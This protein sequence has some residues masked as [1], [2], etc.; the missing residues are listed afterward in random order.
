[1]TASTDRSSSVALSPR[2]QKIRENADRHA[3]DRDVWVRR[4]AFYYREDHRYFRFLVP[5]G[6]RVLDLGCGF[7]DLLAAVK[8]SYGVGLDFSPAMIEVARQR[9]PHLK[10]RVADIE[11]PRSFDGLEGPFDV[12]IV[13]DTIGDMEDVV[14]TFGNLHALC[15]RDTRIIISYHSPLWR[16]LLELGTKWGGR[17]PSE[18]SNWLSLGDISAL[19]SLAGF[20]VI[21]R[22][23]RQIMP[24]RLFGL[25][26]LLNRYVGTVPLIR[27]LSL[28]NYVVV[29]SLKS[30][31]PDYSSC[32]VLIPARNEKGNI[33][34]AVARLP[35]FCEDIEIMF[36][37]G[38]SHDG[39]LEEMERVKACHPDKDIK[40]LVQD[41][42]G[43]G[44]AVRKGF[45]QARG[46][47]LMILDADLTTPPEQMP[48]F[49]EVIRSGRGE[50]ANGTRL[51]YPMENEA[52]RLLNSV[53]N[54]LFSLVFT[55]LLNQ[56]FTDTLCGTKVL[57]RRHYDQIMAS[58]SYF[59]DFDPFGDF[60]LIFGA[61]KLNLKIV[62]VPVRYAGRVYGTT[63]ISRFS[64]GALLLRM[65]L[66]A[67][68][69]LKAI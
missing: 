39:T 64:H 57:S 40:I 60:D 68:R 25:G 47:V 21:R 2:K 69:K 17:M 9:N 22:E 43:K 37:E 65:V 4:N 44:D 8:P 58:R 46:E 51:I 15:S 10:F 18:K 53:A 13:G 61:A 20:E 19:L 67:Y 45:A 24:M 50:F 36:V 38:H 7:G 35:Q 49:F 26:T 12:I 48:Q 31:E 14:A 28:R 11:D 1:M 59:G 30:P 62:E 42:K 41:G 63:Q 16:P 27:A 34:A 55:W 66:F 5:E 23:W 54:R 32:T 29:R 33:E 52:M 6:K 56:R 3:S